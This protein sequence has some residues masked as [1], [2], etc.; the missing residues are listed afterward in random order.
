MLVDGLE[1][2]CYSV[3]TTN[4]LISTENLMGNLNLVFGDK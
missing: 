3:I 2:L 4:Y 1:T